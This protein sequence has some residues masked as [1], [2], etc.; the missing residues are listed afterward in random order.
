M[1]LI[2]ISKTFNYRFDLIHVYK[3]LFL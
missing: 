3:Q 1:L 2:Y